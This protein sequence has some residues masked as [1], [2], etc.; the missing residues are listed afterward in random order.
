[1]RG[2]CYA[3]DPQKGGIRRT[4]VRLIQQP[5]FEVIFFTILAGALGMLK[6]F[7]LVFFSECGEMFCPPPPPPLPPPKKTVDGR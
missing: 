5:L 7:V 3:N 4:C 2:V 6:Q 1:M